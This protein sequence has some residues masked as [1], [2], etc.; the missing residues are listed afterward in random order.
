MLEVFFTLS[1]FLN[2]SLSLFHSQCPHDLTP[3]ETMLLST[4][5]WGR[6]RSSAFP[7]I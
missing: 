5:I 4:P 7:P 3:K 1:L 6:R 2:F